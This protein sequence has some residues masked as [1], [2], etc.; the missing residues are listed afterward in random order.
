WR[1]PSASSGTRPRAVRS[2]RSTPR[3]PSMPSPRHSR[4]TMPRPI[5]SRPS[6]PPPRSWPRCP[7]MW[8]STCSELTGGRMS[9]TIREAV[10]ADLPQILRLV[11]ALAVYERE[12]DA[13]EATEADFAAVMF[14]TEG[15]PNTFGLMAEVDGTVI[16][17][18]IWFRTFSTWTGRNGIWLEDLF[19]DPEY[20]GYGAGK[21]L[22]GRLAQICRDRGADASRMVRAEVEHTLDRV[23]RII[24]REAAGRMGDL[25]PRRAGTGRVREL[26]TALR[27]GRS[28]R[29]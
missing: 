22:L 21:A 4:P 20:R 2:A 5:R 26:G 18:A 13:V 10:E 14:P 1:P 24:G 12:P 3:S 25:P 19:V 8:A 29:Q 17:F 28:P 7:A 16:G 9:V 11:H 15:S 23:L 6:P 27:P